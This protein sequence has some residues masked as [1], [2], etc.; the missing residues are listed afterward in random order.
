[1]GHT[2]FIEGY[3]VERVEG[4]WEVSFEGVEKYVAATL[5]DA[6]AWIEEREYPLS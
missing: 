6:R 3:Q 1:M 5:D 2:Y 4:N